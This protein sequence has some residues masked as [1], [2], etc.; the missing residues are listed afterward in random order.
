M[1]YFPSVVST[2]PLHHST[3]ILSELAEGV[4]DPIA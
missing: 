4:L 2:G 3:W 1:M